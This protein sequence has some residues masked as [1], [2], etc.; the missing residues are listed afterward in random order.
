MTE[1]IADIVLL[2]PVRAGKS[3][4]GRLLAQRLDLPQI[5]IDEVRW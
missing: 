4:V 5:S 1:A 2:G 3:T